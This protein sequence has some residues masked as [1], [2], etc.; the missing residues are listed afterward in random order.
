MKSK[1][2]LLRYR[3]GGLF[4]ENHDTKKEVCFIK[5]L[6]KEEIVLHKAMNRGDFEEFNLQEDAIE[7]SIS[8]GQ[9]IFTRNW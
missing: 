1:E 5:P 7:I 4:C 2:M 8:V 9:T 3:E 6:D